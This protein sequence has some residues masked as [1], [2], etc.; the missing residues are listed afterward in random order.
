MDAV[1]RE[2][3]VDNLLMAK[4]QS[5]WAVVDTMV[6][7]DVLGK[8]NLSAEDCMSLAKELEEWLMDYKKLWRKVSKESELHRLVEIVCWYADYLRDSALK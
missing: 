7:K 4:G 5:L 3:I 1:C 2:K 6:E 8:E